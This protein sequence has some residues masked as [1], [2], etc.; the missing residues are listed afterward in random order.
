MLKKWSI[1]IAWTISLVIIIAQP[2]YAFCG[3]Y[4]AKADASLYNQ[5]SQVII[6]REGDRTILTMTNDYQGSVKDFALVVPVPVVLK[7]GQVKIAD[8]KIISRIDA[9]SAPRLVEYYDS[10]PCDNFFSIDTVLRGEAVTGNVDIYKSKKPNRGVT[11][12]ST[13]SV[14]EYDIVILSAKE[15]DGLETW[16]RENDY[17][18]PA[19][20]SNLL[21]PYI[22]QNM[23][24]F[25]AKV[26]LREF[27]DRGFKS[28]RPLAIAYESSKFMLPIRLGTINADREQDLLVYLL[29]PQG[30]TELVNYRTV[31]IPSDV[32]IP[33]SIQQKFPEFYQAV[34]AKSHRRENERVAFL[35]YA[36]NMANCDPC[37]ADPLS[38]DEL[39]K[40]GV[41]WLNSNRQN[42]VFITR[43]HLR[44]KRETFPEDLRF[45]NTANRES[46]QGR[47]IITHPYT[48]TMKCDGAQS[49][50]QL[51]WKRQ[52]EEATNLAQLTGWTNNN[53]P[54]RPN[55]QEQ[56][57]DPWWNDAWK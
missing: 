51:V 26:N 18:I 31:K 10:N 56:E 34:F 21:S 14:G 55:S 30:Q 47:Y 48:G 54:D 24:F 40:A 39:R 35:E 44:Y 2:A 27:N 4:V 38:E 5:A 41:F 57:D 6:A 20:A 12:E 17:K 13:F 49:Y 11:V 1:L 19:G 52:Q 7:K 50:Q 42:N 46:F 9:F 29:S 25:V 15:S 23:K 22:R 37:A 53:I 33:E 16:L 45:Q 8:E 28:L 43:L 3:F 32:K 36:W